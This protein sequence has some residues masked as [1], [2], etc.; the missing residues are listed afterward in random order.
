MAFISKNVDDYIK[1]RQNP[2]IGFK[3]IK[4]QKIRAVCS[5]C[6][7]QGHNNRSTKCETNILIKNNLIKQIK[8]IVVQKPISDTTDNDIKCISKKLN[9]SHNLCKTLY[10]EIPQEDLM[11]RP[12]DL[13]RY[14]KNLNNNKSSCEICE[15]T[16]LFVHKNIAKKWRGQTVCDTCWDVHRDSR[17]NLSALVD[18]YKPA[19]CVLCFK[20][21]T[22]RERFHFD[23]VNI[24]DKTSDIYSMINEGYDIKNI[25]TEIDKCQRL[26]IECH[27]IITDLENRMGFIKIKTQLAKQK[28]SDEKIQTL[29]KYKSLYQNMFTSLQK[30]LRVELIFM[31]NKKS[32]H[33]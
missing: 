32:H 9:I 20:K 22:G 27:N 2:S 29:I 4:K 23:H 1:I 12:I 3:I 26:C 17:E 15:Q 21:R 30:D 31:R 19:H 33:C 5:N 11:K 13:T 24:F 8:G 18:V 14:L 7:N 16:I 25:Y 6:G 28:E 10:R